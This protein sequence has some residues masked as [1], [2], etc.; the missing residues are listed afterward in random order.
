MPPFCRRDVLLLLGSLACCILLFF[1]PIP[2]CPAGTSTS[3]TKREDEYYSE[4]CPEP[5]DDYGGAAME[6][7]RKEPKTKGNS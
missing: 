4:Y 6:E 5:R 3:R 2:F 1:H 7:A